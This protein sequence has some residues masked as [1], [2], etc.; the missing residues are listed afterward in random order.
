M[1]LQLKLLNGNK[2]LNMRVLK[3]ALLSFLFLFG[4]V[5][6]ISLLIPS[7]IRISKAIDLNS[8]N[9]S[10]YSLIANKDKWPLWHP[11]YKNLN[12]TAQLKWLQE[13]SWKKLAQNDSLIIVEIRPKGKRTITNGWQFYRHNNSQ[14][15]T[16][17]W[18]MDFNLPWYPWQKFSSLFFEGTYGK[19]M[20]NGL[21]NLKQVDQSFPQP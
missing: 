11:A 16:L 19:M 2:K 4:L 6:L 17:Q 21:N 15:Q 3:L 9:D 5:T 20:E 1:V 14:N 7:H 10:A 18:Y 12:D 13:T 8:K